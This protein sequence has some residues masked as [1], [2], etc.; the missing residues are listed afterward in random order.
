MV[1]NN[2]FFST[3]AII[4]NN[5]QK[6]KKSNIFVVAFVFITMAVT[7]LKAQETASFKAEVSSSTINWKGYK[8]TGSHNGTIMLQSGNLSLEGDKISGYFTVDMSTIKDSDGSARLEGHLKSK[9]FFEIEVYTT[10]KFEIT[11]SETKNGKLY[12]TG[13][14][15]IKDVTKEITFSA[16]ISNEEEI[17]TLTSETIQINRADYNIKYKSKSFFNNLKEK[18]IN[19]EFDL[20]VKIVAKK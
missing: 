19:D 11:G 6:M 3:I 2:Y 4:T 12:I 1:I 7:T 9:D 10:S 8:P 18:F 20:Q 15:T 14:L 13:N 17:V 5:N 16:T